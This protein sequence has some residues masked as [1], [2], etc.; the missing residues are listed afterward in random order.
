MS[1]ILVVK[2]GGGAGLDLHAAC[3]DLTHLARTRP[4]IVVHGVSARMAELCE[5]RG[6]T[7]EMLVSPSGHSS[8]Y[9]P[10]HIRDLFVE[11]ADAVN[12]EIVAALES[13]GVRA[14]GLTGDAVLRAQRKDAVRALMNGRVRLIRDDYT[15]TIDR[16]ETARIHS[17]L[18]TGAVAV[19][20]PY[21]MSADGL[22]NVD[23][24]RAGASVA[25][26]LRADTLII[27]S[28]VRGLLRDAHDAD[29]L[30]PTVSGAQLPQAMDAAQGRMKRKVLGAQEAVEQGVRRVIIGD[31]RVR[32]PI[33]AALD[34]QGTV[35]TR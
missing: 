19:I 13:R 33:R 1:E 35:F 23:G 29:S 9:T 17:A 3:D 8:R 25:G 6:V 15:G 28:N 14:L 4:V 26:A 2:L 34:G 30:I 7:V 10:P 24:D 32:Y 20:P 5:S 22:L 21:A 11:A 27:L 12:R 31:G 18:H 16:V